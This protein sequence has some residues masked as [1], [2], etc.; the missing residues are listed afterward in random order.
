[1]STFILPV[2][3]GGYFDNDTRDDVLMEFWQATLNFACFFHP[4]SVK[5][6]LALEANHDEVKIMRISFEDKVNTKD[7]KNE[8]K[9]EGQWMPDPPF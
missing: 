4:V 8:K 1:M 3:I 7:N 5:L 2:L 9:D 6:Q